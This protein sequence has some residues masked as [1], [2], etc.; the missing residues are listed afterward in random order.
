MIPNLVWSI[1]NLAPVSIFCFTL[2]PLRFFYTFLAI[3][4]IP[5]FLKNSFLDKIQIGK[6]TVIYRKLG[7]HII[8]KVAQNGV[9]IN[10]LIR[11][12]FPAHK[13][14]TKAKLSIA[15]LINQTYIFEKFHL[16][17]FLFFCLVIVYAAA[18]RHPF[19][20]WTILLNNIAYNIYPNF[21]QQYIRLKLRLFNNR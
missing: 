10:T 19:W 3:S 1:L 9:I 13:T 16:I 12:K 20:A 21:L 15:R 2:A 11:K 4:L 17:L 7:V 18:N 14:V 8:N 5:L 6:T